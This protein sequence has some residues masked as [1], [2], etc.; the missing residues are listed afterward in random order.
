MARS[1]PVKMSCGALRAT[2]AVPIDPALASRVRQRVAGGKAQVVDGQIYIG[3]DPA[4]PAIGDLRISYQVA[5]PST[6]SLV[7]RQTGTDFS[8]YQTKAGDTLLFAKSGTVPAAEIFAHAQDENRIL[9]WIIRAA[10]TIF[11]MV[12][13]VLLASPLIALAD[14]V[15]FIGAILGVGAMFVGIFM[16]ALVAPTVIAIAWL[17]YRPLVAFA[18]LGAGA[19]VALLTRALA[20]KRKGAAAEP[21]RSMPVA[22][23]S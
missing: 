16:T 19:G 14:V 22:Q 6:V 17:W 18:V 13:F 20:P 4:N 8:A 15:P 3:A 7:G 5:N 10:A 9:T 12:G 2:E 1:G 23:P 11:M 21:P